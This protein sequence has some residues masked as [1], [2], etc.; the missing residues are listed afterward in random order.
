MH[1]TFPLVDLEFG[2]SQLSGKRDLLIT[3]LGKFTDEYRDFEARIAPLLESDKTAAKQQ[4]HTLK[5]VSGNLGLKALHEAAKDLEGDLMQDAQVDASYAAFLGALADTYAEIDRLSQPEE[6]TEEAATTASAEMQH[7]PAPLLAALE[8][9]EYIP[10]GKLDTLMSNIQCD[11]AT[12]TS[13]IDAINDLDY[14]KAI[15]LLR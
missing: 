2:L 1:N 9:N 12:R 3:L 13:I 5:G 8:R 10:P 14:S 11:D 6:Q 7:D 4:V 15:S